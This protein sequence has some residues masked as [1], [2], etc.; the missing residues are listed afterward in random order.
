MPDN[1]NLTSLG[2]RSYPDLETPRAYHEDPARAM[3][4]LIA[5]GSIEYSG[6]DLQAIEAGRE[7]LPFGTPVFVPVLPL[8]DMD[9]RIEAILHLRAAGLDPVPHIAARRLQDRRTALEFL[10]TVHREAGVHRVLLI[11]GDSRQSL[12]PYGQALDLLQDHVLEEAGIAEVALAGYP[13]GHPRVAAADMESA[14]LG[15]LRCLAEQGI[16]AQLVT[17]FTFVPSRIIEYCARIAHLAPDLPI[18]VGLAGPARL[19]ELVHY[20]RYCG[21][22]ASLSAVSKVGVRVAQLVDHRRADEQLDMLARFNAAHPGSNIIGVH[23]F[24]FGGFARTAAWM[25]AHLGAA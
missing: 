4:E 17:Q 20:A 6:G 8:H 25:R 10:A 9:S 24:S 15:K 3:S 19:R 5:D 13:E 21:V 12:G 18:Y 2:K 1:I 23:A 16:G 7:Q 11:G 14:L 22:A